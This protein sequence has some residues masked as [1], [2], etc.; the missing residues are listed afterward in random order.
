MD[1]DAAEQTMNMMMND[2]ADYNNDD[3][4]TATLLVRYDQ[5]T[6]VVINNADSDDHDNNVE[7]YDDDVTNKDSMMFLLINN[8]DN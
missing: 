3:W 4:H 2:A 6:P 5:L 8:N 1:D 7:T